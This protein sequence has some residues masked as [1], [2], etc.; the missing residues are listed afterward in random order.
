[1]I[2]AAARALRRGTTVPKVR[3]WRGRSARNRRFLYVV[4]LF[5]SSARYG[6]D[7]LAR[8]ASGRYRWMPAYGRQRE[9][10]E[11]YGLRCAPL[12]TC[13]SG[14]AYFHGTALETRGAVFHRIR[15]SCFEDRRDRRTAA[16]SESL[17]PL[18][19]DAS[20]QNC[21]WRRVRISTP[22]QAQPWRKW[23]M[24]WWWAARSYGRSRKIQR[25]WKPWPGHSR[26]K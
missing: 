11:P 9:E 17:A 25:V 21:R 7:K 1:M 12:D 18:I 6:L 23:W 19:E 2:R 26:R 3:I 5:E 16:L 15:V 4:H 13:F 14:R 22:E 10:A 8:D 24:E 20:G